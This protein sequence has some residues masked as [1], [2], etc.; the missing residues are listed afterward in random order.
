MNESGFMLDC[1]PE[2][3]DMASE[4][5]DGYHR[6]QYMQNLSQIIMERHQQDEEMEIDDD[7]EDSHHQ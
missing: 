6:E 3:H 1:E 4:E 5:H 7:D 2:D